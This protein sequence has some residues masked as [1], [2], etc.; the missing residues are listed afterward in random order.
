VTYTEPEL[1]NVG[2]TEAQAREAHGKIRILRAPFAENDRAQ[3]ERRTDGLI[4]VITRPNGR[5]LGAAVVGHQ[6]GEIVQPWILAVSQ[7]LKIGAMAQM[8]APYPTLGE[9]GKRAAGS[10]YIPKL[11]TERTKTIVRLLARLG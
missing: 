3:A 10:F 8:I 2:L 6:A 7:E 9:I 11:F 5:I 1:A 4:K